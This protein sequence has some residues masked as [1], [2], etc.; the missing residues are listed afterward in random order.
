MR[1]DS[2]KVFAKMIKKDSGSFLFSLAN[3]GNGALVI[4]MSHVCRISFIFECGR[5]LHSSKEQ[6]LLFG[7][8]VEDNSDSV[9]NF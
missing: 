2:H 1:E 6:F 8:N 5:F 4:G 7:G 9:V 3:G